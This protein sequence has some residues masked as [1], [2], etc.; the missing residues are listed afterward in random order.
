MQTIPNLAYRYD[1]LCCVW[2]SHDADF[3][4][5]LLENI[6]H[7]YSMFFVA[8]NKLRDQK[9]HGLFVTPSAVAD[10]GF[11]VANSYF[12]DFTENSMKLTILDGKG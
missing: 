4:S 1:Y 12:V 3:I 8:L 11:F 7:V 6:F 9:K 2:V 10:P 5:V